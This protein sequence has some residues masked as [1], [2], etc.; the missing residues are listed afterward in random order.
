MTINILQEIQK[1]IIKY[2][3]KDRAKKNAYFFKTGK[4]EYAE[5]DIF[6]GLINEEIRKIAKT[7]S[8]KISLKDIIKLMSSKIHE[9]R[10]LA[11]II[12]VNKFKS[13][14]KNVKEEIFNLYLK[15]IKY[16]NN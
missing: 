11:L 15:N 5:G 10:L 9:E 16:I 14:N 7:F 4:G 8:N 1:E 2:S 13:H 12:L 3:N 6:I